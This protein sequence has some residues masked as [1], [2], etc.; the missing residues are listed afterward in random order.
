MSVSPSLVLFW[1]ERPIFPPRLVL[2]HS[3]T[4]SVL[5]SLHVGFRCSDCCVYIFRI[6]SY[7]VSAFPNV[8]FLY[9]GVHFLYGHP[10]PATSH[11]TP[12][13]AYIEKYYLTHA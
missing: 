2:L 11:H 12:S 9:R 10:H 5:T 13:P 7:L 6:R 1:G 4:P 8:C 3:T